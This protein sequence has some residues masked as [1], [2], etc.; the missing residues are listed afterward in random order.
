MD[1]GLVLAHEGVPTIS[2]PDSTPPDI[3]GADVAALTMASLASP[4]VGYMPDK[5]S[6]LVCLCF[7]Y[8]KCC[9]PSRTLGMSQFRGWIVRRSRSMWTGSTESAQLQIGTVLPHRR[10]GW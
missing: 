8:S 10:E 5:L 6:F 2:L 9:L 1:S 7:K 3:A 4:K